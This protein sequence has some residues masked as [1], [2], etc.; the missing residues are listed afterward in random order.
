MSRA[1]FRDQ[2]V[3][4]KRRRLASVDLCEP[5]VDLASQARHHFDMIEKIAREF[6]LRVL[7]QGRRLR[8]RQ[9]E[10]VLHKKIIARSTESRN[11][12]DVRRVFARLSTGPAQG[13]GA[14]ESPT[15][16]RIL[17]TVLD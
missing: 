14:R 8:K 11:A 10:N 3:D 5:R 13:Q 7:G 16:F 17:N 12:I 6:L 15:Y 1:F 9:V 2:L 4:I